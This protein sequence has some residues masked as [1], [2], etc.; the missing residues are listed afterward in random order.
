MENYF[1][2]ILG[3]I[4][5]LLH[6]PGLVMPERHRE[7]GSRFVPIPSNLRLFG[8]IMLAIGTGA[9]LVRPESG[10]LLVGLYKTIPDEDGTIHRRIAETLDRARH[11]EVYRCL[12][13]SGL[14]RPSGL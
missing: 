10:S 4:V 8:L 1:I 5:F 2:L 12:S 7:L 9:V 11:R 3:V 14:G 13:S 6:V